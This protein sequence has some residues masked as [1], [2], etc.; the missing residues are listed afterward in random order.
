MRLN[1]YTLFSI[2]LISV[3]AL[4]VS[5]KPYLTVQGPVN[6]TLYQ[7][8]SVFLGNLGPGQSFYIEASPSTANASGAYVNVGWDTL[9]ALNLPQG[10]SAQAS[11][12]Y[13]NPMKL[14]ITASPYA[15]GGRYNLTIRAVNL[16]NYSKIGNLTINAEVNVT[17][18][19][20]NL[21]VTPGVVDTGVSLPTNLYIKINNTGISEDPFLININGLPAWNVSEEV[22]AQHSAVS[23]F[24]YP[25]YVDEPGI[26]HINLTATSATSPLITRSYPIMLNAQASL[27]NDYYAVGQGVVISPVIMEPAYSFMLLLSD[28][29]RLLTG[30]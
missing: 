12:L 26:Y 28:C 11:P 24:V 5:A 17:Q 29:Y 4:G 16:Q 15:Q 9:E 21:S 14:K 3:L 6:G 22:I 20:F 23:T 25:V 10:W 7:N 8:G 30:Q 13:E 19:V 1:N 27:L 18:N 2:A